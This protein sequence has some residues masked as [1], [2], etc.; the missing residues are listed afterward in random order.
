VLIDGQPRLGRVLFAHGAGAPMDSE[1]MTEMAQNMA[2]LGLEV[3]RFE[4]PYMQVI[5]ETGKRRPPN[6][7]PQ[8][9][10]HFTA[11][12]EQYATTE[13]PFYLAGKSMG[14]RVASMLLENPAVSAGFV[15]GYPFHPRGKADNLRVDHLQ[16]LEKNLHIFQGERDPMGSFQEV[17]EYNL[18]RSVQVHWL[19]DGDHDLKPRKSS[20]FTQHQHLQRIVQIIGE[21]LN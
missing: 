13:I 4:F 7:M 11:L 14:G 17:T 8:L 10:E 18:A 9:L 16:T 20:G 6:P 21:Q 1:F 19:E 3:I 2:Q 5:R 12:V 15:F